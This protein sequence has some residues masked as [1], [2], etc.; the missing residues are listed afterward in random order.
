MAHHDGTSP[1]SSDFA[2]CDATDPRQLLAAIG[3][4]RMDNREV[5]GRMP[6]GMCQGIHPAGFFGLY[7][8]GDLF[9][10]L[11]AKMPEP[12]ADIKSDFNSSAPNTDVVAD[13][14]YTGPRI[15]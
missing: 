13:M 10:K 5:V 1:D 2:A 4:A 9:N 6:P 3:E 14:N 11:E 15:G 12:Y 8:N 7:G